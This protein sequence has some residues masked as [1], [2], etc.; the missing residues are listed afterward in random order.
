MYIAL[1]SLHALVMVVFHFLY[2]F[3][4]DWTSESIFL[5]PLKAVSSLI[6]HSPVL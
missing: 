6:A 2:C 5:K 4:D 3:E 1:I